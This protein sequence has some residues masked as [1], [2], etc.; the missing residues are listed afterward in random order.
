MELLARSHFVVLAV[1][2]TGFD[3]KRRSRFMAKGKDGEA[4]IEAPLYFRTD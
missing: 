2:F 3:M 1:I 4:T